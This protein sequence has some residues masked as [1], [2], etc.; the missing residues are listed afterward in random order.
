M[1]STPLD[2]WEGCEDHSTWAP[3]QEMVLEKWLF[4][5]QKYK[6]GYIYRLQ[7]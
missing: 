1:N 2:F 7:D 5:T 4:T 3:S 6:A